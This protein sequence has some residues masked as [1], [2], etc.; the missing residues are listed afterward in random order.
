MV[1]SQQILRPYFP[2]LSKLHIGK[3]PNLISIPLAPFIA[4]LDLRIVSEELLRLTMT[5]ATAEE[6]S[7]C[8]ATPLF[9][10]HSGLKSLRMEEIMNLESF[11]Q[12]QIQELTSLQQL[13]ILSCPRLMKLP[14]GS[15]R[16]LTS[17]RMLTLQGRDGLIHEDGMKFLTTQG[18]YLMRNGCSTMSN[19]YC[20]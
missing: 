7:A 18:S 8:S 15:F 14:E 6:P 5:K 4:E 12:K 16:G 11:P 20:S 10:S 13:E 3:C 19:K 17:L 2:C 1:E 9:P